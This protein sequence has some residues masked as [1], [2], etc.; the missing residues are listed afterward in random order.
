M[1]ITV[2]AGLGSVLTLYSGFGLGTVLLPAFAT[3][4]PV[5]IAVAATAVVHCANNALKCALL[6][7]HADR[8]T[9][10]RFG[11]PA[12]LAALAGA[13]VLAS[14]TQLPVLATYSL[15]GHL[16]TITPLKL[17]MAVLMAGFAGLELHPR[18][19]ALQVD[20]RWLPLG[21]VLSGFF[22]GLSGHQG[23]LRSAFLAKT[24]LSTQAFVGTN[25]V[26][27]MV[28]DVA[29]LGVYVVGWKTTGGHFLRFNLLLT[30]ACGI[31]AAFGGVLFGRQYL[32]KVTM[33]GVQRLTGA[34]LLLMA[35]ALGCGVL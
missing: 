3:F 25:A 11:L 31:A 32:H 27:G 19:S 8:A 29:R 10:V 16:A 30:L 34:L 22:G 4:L 28:V 12:V 17:A 2:V 7:K 23:A 24:G 18:F 13:A 35:L 26:I 14:L 6:A 15:A 21:G 20:Q 33:R 1:L 5:H 9:L